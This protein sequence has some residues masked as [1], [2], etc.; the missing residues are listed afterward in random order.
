MNDPRRNLVSGSKMARAA[1]CPGSVAMERE[2]RKSGRFFALPDRA[3]A[4]GI[5]IHGWNAEEALGQT[6]KTELDSGEL[7][8]AEK[9]VELR[10]TLLD[11]WHLDAQANGDMELIVE[12]RFWYRRGLIPLFSAQ[13]DI[14]VIDRPHKRALIMDYKTGRL[15]TDEAADN[16]QL[17]TEAVLLKHNFPELEEIRAAIIEPWVSW[18]PVEVEYKGD[19]LRQAENQIVAIADRTTWE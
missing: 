16:L 8:T 13:I 6:P 5:K 14:A 3:R 17:R 9:C 11:S 10:Q 18:D 12:K 7:A 19:D 15:E 4:S 2:V 1:E